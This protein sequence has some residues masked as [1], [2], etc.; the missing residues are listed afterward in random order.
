[1]VPT[2]SDEADQIFQDLQTIMVR[3]H[4]DYGPRNISDAY[5]GPMNGLLVRIGDKYARI[6]HLM[7]D[8]ERTANFESLEDSFLDLANYCVIAI[9]VMRGKW[10]E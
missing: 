5:G 9:L 4:Q 8:K 10:E 2:I 6:K 3:K 7:A 1:M